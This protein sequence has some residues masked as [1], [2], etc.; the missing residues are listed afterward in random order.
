MSIEVRSVQ[1]LGLSSIVVTLPKQWARRLGLEPGKKVMLVDEGSSIRIIPLK[2]GEAGKIVLNAEKL[3]PE[4]VENAPICVYLSG[5]DSVKIITGNDPDL[6]VRMQRKALDLMGL[7][8]SPEEDGISLKVLLDPDKVDLSGLIKSLDTDVRGILSLL[9]EVLEGSSTSE[10]LQSKASFLIKSFFRKHYMILRYL[11]LRYPFHKDVVVSYQTALATSYIGFSV[12]LLGELIK[13]LSRYG[14]RLD[15]AGKEGIVELLDMFTEVFHHV[16]RLIVNPS[17][18]R[19]IYAL[20]LLHQA[21][22]RAEQLVFSSKS[23]INAAIVVRLDD[24]MRLLNISLYVVLCK[25]LVEAS[26]TGSTK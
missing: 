18:K 15:D 21:R 6:M 8:I 11:S 17:V 7:H 10:D 16:T 12:D 26:E 13:T 25:I 4:I 14:S 22:S 3:P 23:P 20:N 5:L 1:R 2:E 24:A 19:L 9:K